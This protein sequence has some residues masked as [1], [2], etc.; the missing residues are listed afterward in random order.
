[1]PHW[2]DLAGSRQPLSDSLGLTAQK[3]TAIRFGAFGEYFGAL[4]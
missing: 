1:M 4:C 2:N 3:L